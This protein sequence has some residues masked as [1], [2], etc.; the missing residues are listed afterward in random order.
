M[1]EA[2]KRID[3]RLPE[4][5]RNVGGKTPSNVK[6]K[7]GPTDGGDSGGNVEPTGGTASSNVVPKV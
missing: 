7:G 5:T 1:A 6:P 4:I 3:S 2:L